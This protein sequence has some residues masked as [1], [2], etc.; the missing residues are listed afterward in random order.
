MGIDAG[1]EIMRLSE[2]TELRNRLHMR[3]R[4][5]HAFSGVIA[6]TEGVV[7]ECFVLDGKRD[8]VLVRF[9]AS[10]GDH[11]EAFTRTERVDE[12][13]ILEVIE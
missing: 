9:K 7:V 13:A 1:K 3:V 6:G 12:A 5:L 11:F 10:R 4:A 2:V 8:G